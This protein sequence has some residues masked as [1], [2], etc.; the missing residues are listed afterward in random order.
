MKAREAKIPPPGKPRLEEAAK[1]TVRLY[2]EWSKPE[3]AAD[4]RAKLA[5]PSDAPKP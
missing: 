3:K 2:E 4:W 5:K 1:R